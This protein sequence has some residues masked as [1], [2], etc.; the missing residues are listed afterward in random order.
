MQLLV[1]DVPRLIGFFAAGE[2]TGKGVDSSFVARALVFSPTV[3]AAAGCY[4]H[5]RDVEGL[6]HGTGQAAMAAV[7]D[8]DDQLTKLLLRAQII[9]DEAMGTAH[10]KSCHAPAVGDA[11]T[12]PLLSL[13]VFV[14]RQSPR[15]L[16]SHANLTLTP[17][18][19]APPAC[20]WCAH[21]YTS[22]ATGAA[23]RR[24]SAAN[25]QPP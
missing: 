17:T 16:P 15:A 2:R 11:D 13:C 1:R 22:V 20:A 3:T 24:D 23:A 21:D 18:R 9:M 5:G 4:G 12:T 6:V 25:W 19:T 7:L 8:V 10:H 14:P